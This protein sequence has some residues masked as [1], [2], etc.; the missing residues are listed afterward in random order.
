MSTRLAVDIGGTFTDIVLDR[1]GEEWT[2][3]VLTTPSAPADG[4]MTGVME[5]LDVSGVKPGDIDLILHGTTLATNALIERKGAVTALFVTQGHRD[6]L[7][8]AYE[9]RFDQYDLMADR[10]APLVPRDLRMPVPERVNARG[11]VLIALDEA[12][13]TAWLDQLEGLNVGS[14]GVGLLHAYANPAHEQRIGAMITERFP[15]MAISLS[16]DVCPE[17]RE[18]ERQTTTAANAYVKPTIARYLADVEARLSE[19]GF[20]CPCLLM[21]SGGS[22]VTIA[23]A[24][25]FP[26]RLIESGPAGGAILAGHLAKRLGEN[27]VVSFD[28]GGTTAK[29]CLIDDGEPLLGRVFEVDRAHRCMKG[30]GMPLKI[31]VVEMVEIG[32]GGG[33]LASVDHLGRIH[34]GPESAGADPGPA[35]Y[36]QGGARP[37]VTDANL[38]L[39]RLD[40]DVFA[41]GTL[42]LDTPAAAAVLDHHVGQ[43]LSLDSGEAALGVIE[44]VDENMASAARVHAVERG[45]EIQN[46]TMIAFGGAAPLH[47]A[48]LAEKLGIEKVVIPANA[49]VG[50]AVG[51]LLA[52]VAYEVV[53]SRYIRMSAFDAGG[54]NALFGVMSE[55]AREVVALGAPG[56]PVIE[57]RHAYARYIGQGHEVKIDLPDR[58]LEAGDAIFVA[59]AFEEAY[60]QQFGRTVPGL[61]VE[62]LTWSVTVY[63]DRGPVAERETASVEARE[64]TSDTRRSVVFPGHAERRDASIHQRTGLAGGEQVAGPAAIAENQ[65]TTM[66]PPGWTGGVDGDGNLTLLREA[67]AVEIADDL[68]AGLRHQVL[69]DRLIAIVEEQAQAIIR[70]AF[71]TTVREAGDLSAGVF[72]MQGRMLAQ[73]VT[74]TPG[75]VNAMAASVNFFLA[76]YPPDAMKEG[77]VYVTNDP[78][79]GTGHLFD[80]TV[81]TPTFRNGAPI[82]LFASTVHVV[83]IGGPGFGPDAGQ[84]YEEGLC[85]PIMRLFDGGEPNDSVFD[86]VR[87]NVREPVQVVGDLYSLTTSNDVGCR[88]LLDLMNEFGMNGLDEIADH[89]IDTSRR[90]MLDE[91]RRLP[92][93]SW[94]QEMTVDGYDKA[95]DLKA[96]VTIGDDGIDV[97]FTG[98]SGVSPFG[99]N[100]PLTYTQAYASFGI[101]SIIGREV[102]NNDGSL[103]PVRVTA[104]EG[105]ILNAPR[106]AAVTVR[107]VIGQ[108]L[109]DVVLGCLGQA[110]P[111]SVPAEG[112]SSLWNPSLL[113]G[114]GVT[115]DQDYGDATPFSVTIFHSGGT[116]ARPGKHGLSATAF[117]S[118]VRNTPVE[119][120]E[121]ISP[122]I[123]TRKEL[124][125]GSGGAGKF[126][127]GD[128]QV[129]ELEHGEGAPFAVLALFDRIDHPAR[130]RDGGGDAGPGAI[131]LSGGKILKGKG[132]QI[133]PAG[134]RLILELPGGGGLGES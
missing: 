75:H 72:D 89:I 33:S 52:P 94:Q 11:E 43:A 80:F 85:I 91:V 56:E 131:R 15:T 119:I 54:L 98:T 29:I 26:V 82:G 84:V 79:L 31:P 96:T 83:D 40:A 6:S 47:A 77:D 2:G 128:G 92:K 90:A 125:P 87:A 69:W 53:R 113:G 39:G 103:E 10:T 66:V 117:P 58:P 34:V 114:H 50:S 37:A 88:R 30:S 45:K 99:I 122:M 130:G 73:A 41:G 123:F 71:S 17:I 18:Y 100:V 32:A 14:V 134:E 48:R 102:P 22:L 112:S 67:Y 106:P 133:V 126:R 13:V 65:T 38:I 76:K 121:S 21:T 86:I 35:C 97:D 5:V 127:G 108:M 27:E 1:D 63:A 20:T 3:K 111:G 60:R 104:P 61:E 42:K 120:T 7:E 93:G 95:V 129:I 9:N 51:F 107:H 12:A 49:G 116:G 19:T 55:E 16:S 62:V 105:C 8:I 46:R 36:G 68:A 64:V 78:W 4:F 115:G 24:R 74:G 28:M 59:D 81:V 57:R 25:E 23:T 110:V 109:P 124:T 44:I 101:R 118:G 132:K 70:T